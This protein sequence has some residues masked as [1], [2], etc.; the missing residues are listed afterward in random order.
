MGQFTDS[1]MAD[2]RRDF[3]DTMEVVGPEMVADIRNDLS[4]PVQRTKG[5]VIRSKSPEP[6]RYDKGGLWDRVSLENTL[7]PN[8]MLVVFVTGKVAYILNKGTAHI[9]GPRIFWGPAFERWVP[10]I[11]QALGGGKP[12]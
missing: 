10:R 6:P 1:I 12:V 8:T 9:G 7:S 11:M 3:Y 5:K 2:L 4:V